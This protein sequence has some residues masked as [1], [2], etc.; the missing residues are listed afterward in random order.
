MKKI[1]VLSDTHGS[2]SAFLRV[3][4]ANPG[5]AA[6]LFLGDGWRDLERV[7]EE[8]AMPVYSVRG[9]C[10]FGSLDPEEGLSAFEG[11][12][13]YY[14]HGHQYGV[15]YGLEELARA[16]AA[17]GADVALFGHTHAAACR[18]IGGVWLFNPGSA[19]LPRSGRPSYGLI[20]VQQGQPP[21]LEHFPVPDYE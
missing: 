1:I 5:A 19:A 17:R 3:A 21:R 15:K 20:T 8:L 7:R 6:L 11:V 18:Q 10:D 16:A 2:A 14:V 13:L 12:L 4:Q 9:N